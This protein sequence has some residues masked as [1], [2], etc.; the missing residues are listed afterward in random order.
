MG[1]QTTWKTR[2]RKMNNR[3]RNVSAAGRNLGHRIILLH[4]HLN[5][6]NNKNYICEIY[7]GSEVK[8]SFI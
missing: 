8:R 2:L 3:L 7:A 6:T 4:F 5:S 1:K